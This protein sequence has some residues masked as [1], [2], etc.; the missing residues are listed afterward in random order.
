MFLES[1][2]KAVACSSLNIHRCSGRA[3][4]DKEIGWFKASCRV[5]FQL[6]RNVRPNVP[7]AGIQGSK[8][9]SGL[10]WRRK[11]AKPDKDIVE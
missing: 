7:D 8:S 6:K 2:A 5:R 1:Q 10:W 11:R 4:E 9:L 3:N